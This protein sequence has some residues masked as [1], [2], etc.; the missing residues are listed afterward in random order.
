MPEMLYTPT[1]VLSAKWNLGIVLISFI[2][3]WNPLLV[4][5]LTEPASLDRRNALT[6]ISSGAAGLAISTLPGNAKAANPGGNDQL[7]TFSAYNIL[8][9]SVNM[10]PKLQAVEPIKFLQSIARK[11][12][13]VWLG[14]HHN[15][16]KDHQF[17]AELVQRLHQSRTKANV[18]APMAIGLEQVQ[19][20]FQPILDDYTS[21]KISL[22]EMKQ[23][24]EWEKRWMWDFENYRPIF[25]AA[26]RL[27]I[28]LVALNVDSEDLSE[29]EK[30]GYARLPLNRLRK[31]IKDPVGFGE[32]AKSRQFNTYSSYV[33]S[34]SYKIHQKLGLLSYTM[35][36]EKLDDE[37]TFSRFLSGRILWDEGMAS[38][39]S[40]WCADNPGGLMLGLVG[41]DH[42]KFANGIPAR[43]MRMTKDDDDMAC[44][45]VII[46]PTLIDSRPS[47]SVA[48]VPGAESVSADS[49]T[50]QLRY[51]KDDVDPT[52][53]E[54]RKLPES[55]GGVLKFSDY[56][57]VTA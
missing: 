22:E 7:P 8:P 50:L 13:S 38:A 26:E 47:G 14:E 18:K 23:G 39:A 2:L 53:D 36:G 19:R 43:F 17:Q 32:F 56:I 33:I 34:P 31:Y 45:T 6:A 5:G 27:N 54:L 37:M 52:N 1:S 29:V 40:T 12:G 30:G 51:L 49:I 46:N 4:N 55:T 24:V 15:S 48:G 9:D 28:R 21:G 42:V 35:N 20:Q 44:T 11:G 41:A 16:Q 25:E 3:L 57:I 10:D